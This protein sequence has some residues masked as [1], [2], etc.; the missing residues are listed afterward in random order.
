MEL[1]MAWY[2]KPFLEASIGNVIRRLCNEKVA[3][4]VDPVRSG[5]SVKDVEKSV[6]QLIYWCRE[7]WQQIYAV[8]GECPQ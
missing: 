7:F 1:C 5:K 3:I 8:R 4:E 6:D 2:G